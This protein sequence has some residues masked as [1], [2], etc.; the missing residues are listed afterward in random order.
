MRFLAS[1]RCQDIVAD[2]V[3]VLPAIPASIEK[4]K[5]KFVEKSVDISVFTVHLDEKMTFLFPITDHAADIQAI[6]QPAMDA[7]MPRN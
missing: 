6:M 1:D 5:A 3:V 2:H 4:V 7:V